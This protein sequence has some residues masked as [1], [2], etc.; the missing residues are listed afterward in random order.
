MHRRLTG[1]ESRL[2]LAAVCLCQRIEI[3]MAKSNGALTCTAKMKLLHS[4][5]G[6]TIQNTK[7]AVVGKRGDDNKEAAAARK[8]LAALLGRKP[9]EEEVELVRADNWPTGMD[10]C[11]QI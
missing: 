11:C 5:L 10:K 6:I 2:P 1:N 7:Q 8:V 9:T 4:L 3:G